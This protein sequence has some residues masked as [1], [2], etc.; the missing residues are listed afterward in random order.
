MSSTP[1]TERRPARPQASSMAAV[2]LEG[3][4]LGLP[5]STGYCIVFLGVPEGAAI[6]AVNHHVGVVAPSTLA[7]VG[8]GTRIELDFLFHLP[9]GIGRDASRY[10]DGGIHVCA[11]LAVADRDIPH[12][13]LCNRSHPAVAQIRGKRSGLKQRHGAVIRTAG[14]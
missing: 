1:E 8:S 12:F 4:Q 10:I 7:G 3:S 2:E 6:G 13:V 14:D 5:R 9:G 11:G